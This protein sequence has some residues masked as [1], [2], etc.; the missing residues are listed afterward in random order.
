M[1]L[2]G[3]FGPLLV[4]ACCEI[5]PSDAAGD[6]EKLTRVIRASR[7]T[8]MQATPATWT[9]LFRSGWRNE[10]GVRIVC[11]DVNQRIHFGAGKLA[12]VAGEMVVL[13]DDFHG[14]IDIVL[15]TFDGEAV[16]VEVRAD[17]EGVFE[18]THI[19][20]ERAEKRFNLSGD[21]DGTSHSVGGG[22]CGAGGGAAC[23][24]V[25]GVL[26]QRAY[27]VLRRAEYYR[28]AGEMGGQ[29]TCV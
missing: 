5:C 3:L 15:V 25:H 6:V 16:V 14:V 10:E 24:L 12:A 17:V 29:V 22:S 13:L 23:D 4:G 27:G 2:I 21:V 28:S 8:V 7:P 9:M 18:Q 20:I 26:M 1:L 11:G 19:F